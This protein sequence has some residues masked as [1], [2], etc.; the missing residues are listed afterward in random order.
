MMNNDC[1]DLRKLEKMQLINGWIVLLLTRTH[2]KKFKPNR[3]D[4]SAALT[5]SGN[6]V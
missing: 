5:Y 6:H 1:F 4:Y 3:D 2:P